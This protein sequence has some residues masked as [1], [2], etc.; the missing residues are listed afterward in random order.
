[1]AVYITSS[2]ASPRWMT[3]RRKSRARGSPERARAFSDSLESQVRSPERLARASSAVERLVN[4][5]AVYLRAG[6]LLTADRTDPDRAFD[7]FA[8]QLDTDRSLQ[9]GGA[10]GLCFDSQLDAREVTALIARS[11]A[12]DTLM[13]ARG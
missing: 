3:L 9:T 10:L 7:A 8:R 1:M 4:A 2:A 5:N 6:S 11:V 13:K 12:L